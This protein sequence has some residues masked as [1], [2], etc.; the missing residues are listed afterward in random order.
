MAIK[1]YNFDFARIDLRRTWL[2]LGAIQNLDRPTTVAIAEDL[3]FSPGTVQ[4]IVKN[5]QSDQW[6]DLDVEMDGPV[7]SVK[8]W[9]PTNPDFFTDYHSAFKQK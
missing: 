6:P 1:K 4:K 3:D 7:F 2:V 8:K 9:G 5:L